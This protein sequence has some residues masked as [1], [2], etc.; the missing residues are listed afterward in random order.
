VFLVG[1]RPE[2]FILTANSRVIRRYV[3]Q[4]WL[5]VEACSGDHNEGNV[6]IIEA[7]LSAVVQVRV[8]ALRRIKEDQS[9]HSQLHKR[10]NYWLEVLE[11][12]NSWQVMIYVGN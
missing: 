11:I 3:P 6:R 7:G 5:T 2:V 9:V 1:H 8:R 4:L 12:G 10:K